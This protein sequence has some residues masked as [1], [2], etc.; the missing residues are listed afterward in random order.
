MGDKEHELAAWVQE[1]T[2]E[3]L[4]P[5]A[6]QLRAQAARVACK[7]DVVFG[8]EDGLPGEEWLRSFTRRHNLS[9][10]KTTPQNARL[11]GKEATAAAKEQCNAQQA[12]HAVSK[13]KSRSRKQARKR[14]KQ[15]LIAAVIVSLW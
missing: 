6:A 9:L 5:T 1:S 4:P 8:T 10:R 14:S 7:Y 12:A 13:A 3:H 11:A 15:V 2:A